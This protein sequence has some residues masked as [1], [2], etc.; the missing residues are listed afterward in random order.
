MRGNV[1]S[2][3]DYGAFVE[4]KEGVEGL[5]HISEMSWTQH[6]RHPSKI[7]GIGDIVEVK[8][9]NGKTDAETLYFADS[10]TSYDDR[11][12]EI[13]RATA[14]V[15]A[16]GPEIEEPDLGLPDADEAMSGVSFG[17]SELG[18]GEAKKQVVENF[19][20]GYLLAALRRLMLL[21]VALFRTPVIAL[22]PDLTPSPLRSKA[23]GVINLMGGVGTVIS[24]F[25]IARLFDFNII[26]PFITA[27][28]RDVLQMVP[29]VLKE[30]ARGVGAT[31]WE[32]TR[33]IA[34]KYG[35]RGIVGAVFLGFGRALGET[36]AVMMV[37]GNAPILP[38]GL[39]DL[40]S[41]VR[42]M[43]AT[44]AAEMLCLLA[45]DREPAAQNT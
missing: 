11:M 2:I 41:P 37:T 45:A 21:A 3:T 13:G 30:S 15:L 22:M 38:Q 28:T 32:A 9:L 31:M 42:T 20:R 8:V 23:N 43:T 19:E 40:F 1:V 33:H 16:A 10:I 17:D 26:L 7:L 4:L 6:I 5:I 29:P 24:A 18:F 34:L 39:R 25:V 35:R 44:I 36:M 27:V 14:A 12:Q